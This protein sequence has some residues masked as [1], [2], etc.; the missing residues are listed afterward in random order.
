MDLDETKPPKLSKKAVSQIPGFLKTVKGR[1]C[2]LLRRAKFTELFGP[3]DRQALADLDAA[4][5]LIRTVG[6]Q[7]QTRVRSNEAKTRVYAIIID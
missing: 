4:A 1:R 2:L 3:D 5:R 6:N 7:Y